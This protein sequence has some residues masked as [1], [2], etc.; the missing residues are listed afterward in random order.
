MSEGLIE[1]L[2]VEIDAAFRRHGGMTAEVVA[3][4]HQLEAEHG[5]DT[6]LVAWKLSNDRAQLEF[7][8]AIGGAR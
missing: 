1:Q 4:L 5:R 8:K 6:M 7:D 2:A 3:F